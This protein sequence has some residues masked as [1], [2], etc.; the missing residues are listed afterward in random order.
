[1]R[2][3][4]PELLL[5]LHPSGRT[6]SPRGSMACADVDMDL[7]TAAEE[8]GEADYKEALKVWRYKALEVIP[9]ERGPLHNLLR[10]QPAALG[11]RASDTRSI[12]S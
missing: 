12:C 10:K 7:H 4:F 2:I 8:P 1:M 3:D 9:E 5:E 11:V 6:V